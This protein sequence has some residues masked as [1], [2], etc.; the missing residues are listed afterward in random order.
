MLNNFLYVVQS[1]HPHGYW[2]ELVSYIIIQTFPNCCMGIQH[3]NESK[4]SVTFGS[5]KQLEIDLDL[6]L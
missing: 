3:L 5:L 4:S 2:K 1:Y 6:C